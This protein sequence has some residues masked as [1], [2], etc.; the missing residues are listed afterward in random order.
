MSS[1]RSAR[2]SGPVLLVSGAADAT[3]YTCPAG[4]VALVKSIRAVCGSAG[5]AALRIGIGGTNAPQR[6]VSASVTA[7]GQFV[8]PDTDPIVLVAGEQLKATTS[9]ADCTVTLSGAELTA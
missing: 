3:L 8:D 4:K 5:P 9:G 6:V 1:P 7:S 2:L